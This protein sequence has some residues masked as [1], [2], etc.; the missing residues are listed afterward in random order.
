MPESGVGAGVGKQIFWNHFNKEAH[1]KQV[2]VRD[3]R[4]ILKQGRRFQ[5]LRSRPANQGCQTPVDLGLAISSLISDNAL[6]LPYGFSHKPKVRPGPGQAFS[7][8]STE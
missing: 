5:P 3:F 8:G 1:R 2:L 6:D 7:I 4:K